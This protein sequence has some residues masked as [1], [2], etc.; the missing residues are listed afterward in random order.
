M[1]RYDIVMVQTPILASKKRLIHSGYAWKSCDDNVTK[2]VV[3]SCYDEEQTIE[4]LHEHKAW[5]L[6]GEDTGKEYWRAPCRV[7]VLAIF[8]VDTT[9]FYNTVIFGS[10]DESGNPTEVMCEDGVARVLSFAC[11]HMNSVNKFK[12]AVN[13]IYQSGEACYMEGNTGIGSTGNHVHMEVAEGWQYNKTKRD[14]QWL[15]PNLTNIANV[16]Y[17]L[18]GWNV[19]RN[20]NGYTFKTVESREVPEEPS[21][22]EFKASEDAIVP[23]EPITP[24]EPEFP[25]DES[26]ECERCKSIWSLVIKF[27]EELYKLLFKK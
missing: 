2:K 13:K 11:T 26:Q 3:G 14:G 1:I 4:K 18:D 25:S 20:L 9:G 10:C 24:I 27:V 7:K 6:N 12:L 8:S 19:V 17:Q 23:I 15:L 16:F 5:D 22:D 21:D